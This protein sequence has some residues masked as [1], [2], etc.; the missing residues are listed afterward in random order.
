MRFKDAN[1]VQTV[2]QNCDEV[3][4]ERGENRAKINRL[5]NG[6][7]LIDEEEARKIGL[8]INANLGEAAVI[9]QHGR[10]QYNQAFNSRSRFFTVNIP[11][12]PERKQKAWG[13]FISNK[14]NGYLKRSRP[15]RYCQRHQWASVLLHGMAPKVWFGKEKVIPKFVALEDF[16][17]PTDTECSLENLYWFGVRR[18][19]TPGKLA[20]ASEVED[21]G[22]NKK[23]VSNILKLYK[24][25]NSQQINYDWATQPEKLEELFKQNGIFDCYDAVPTI[26][27]W[28]FYFYDDEKETWNLCLVPDQQSLGGVETGKDFIY[29][30]KKP[31]SDEIGNILHMQFGD[32]NNKAPFLIHSIRGL[33]FLLMEPIFHSNLLQCRLLQHIHEHMNIWLRSTDPAGRAKAQLVNLYNKAFLP[34][35][36]SIVPQDERHQ[37]DVG[38]VDQGMGVTEKLKNEASVTYTQGGESQK[39]SETATAVMA[40]V[41][42]VNA[43]MSA[44]ISQSAE[45][46]RAAYEEICRRFCISKTEE[47]AAKRFQEECAKFGI[48]NVFVNVELWDVEPEVPIGGGNPT[49]EMAK[50]QQLMANREKF[51]PQAQQEILHEATIAW[52]DDAKKAEAWVPVDN[53]PGITAGQE[54]AEL[55]FGALMLGVPVTP[56]NQFNPIDQIETLIGSLSG[57]ITRIEKTGNT[58]TAGEI[59]GLHNVEEYTAALIAQLGQDAQQKPTAKQFA[60]VLG[61][62]MNTV[63]GFEQRLAAQNGQNG[64]GDGKAQAAMAQAATKIKISEAKAQQNQRHKEAAFAAE[65][66]RKDAETFGEIQRE[67]IKTANRFSPFNP[68]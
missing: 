1:Q 61:R 68:H 28:N 64:N 3:E 10:R 11:D 66:R 34:E 67:H 46:E 22:W 21:K 19:W 6:A 41:S 29:N 42:S 65:Q 45:E 50:V 18:Y 14:I 48:P 12:A 17:V 58:A 2:L 31:V 37:I 54:H 40:R 38:L 24:D 60:Q 52:T 44:L 49:M 16:R 39:E 26:P 59:V 25:Q 35:G 27:I 32:L 30:S 47:P 4:W 56:K 7:P 20:K 8:E 51:P 15:Y 57:V 5:F 53:A 63:K 33:G 13:S 43:L 36:L 62:L 9:A 23:A 55:A